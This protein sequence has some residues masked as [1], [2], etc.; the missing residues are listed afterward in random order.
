MPSNVLTLYNYYK[1][2]H[3]R[4][5]T[6][7]NVPIYVFYATIALVRMWIITMILGT[8]RV[9]TYYLAMLGLAK[10]GRIMQQ[11]SL[12]QEI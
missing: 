1:C 3:T 4:I 10:I 11:E 2:K 12:K 9:C 7:T 5:N 6:L 8:C